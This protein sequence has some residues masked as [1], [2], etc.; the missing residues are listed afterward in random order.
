MNFLYL[1]D[2]IVGSEGHLNFVDLKDTAY[3]YHLKDTFI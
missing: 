1:K 3:A 2:T